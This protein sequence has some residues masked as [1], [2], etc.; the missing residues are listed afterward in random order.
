MKFFIAL[1]GKLVQSLAIIAG[2]MALL[3][4]GYLVV[5]NAGPTVRTFVEAPSN[6]EHI[7]YE[8]QV[9]EEAIA[10]RDAELSEHRRLM[11][12]ISDQIALEEET[13]NEE[14][15]ANVDA[16]TRRAEEHKAHVITRVEANRAEAARSLR[17]VEA[18]Y[19]ESYN[20]L[21]WLTCR[22]IK[23]RKAALEESVA[24][25]REALTQAAQR[26]EDEARAQ[27]E[28]LRVDG[29]RVIEE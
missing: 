22:A 6:L 2:L 11:E 23:E 4:L 16:L 29:A 24:M 20:P 12:S 5:S 17:E 1:F 28:E 18:R 10:A 25:Q 15:A 19:C 8:V 14:L 7:R 21:N 13:F 27:A 3:F 26:L 9:G